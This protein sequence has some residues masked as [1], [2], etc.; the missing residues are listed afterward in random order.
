MSGKPS[1]VVGISELAR[2]VSSATGTTIDTSE[3]MIS[4]LI[5]TMKE[6]LSQDYRVQLTGFGTFESKLRAPRTARN[7]NTGEFVKVE[8]R[9]RPVFKPSEQLCD[10]VM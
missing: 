7:I 3:Q 10:A 1:K 8:S 2:F 5:M 6:A 9:K 4:A